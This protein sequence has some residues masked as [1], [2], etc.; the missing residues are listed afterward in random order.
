MVRVAIIGAGLMGGV[1]ARGYAT[2]SERV[3]L[4]LIHDVNPDRAAVLADT[5]GTE[6]ALTLDDVLDDPEVEAVTICVPPHLN[7]EIAVRALRAGKHVFLEKPIAL[8][9]E[10]ADAILAAA[11]QSRTVLMVGLVLRFWPGYAELRALACGGELG[12]P[13]TVTTSRLQPPAEWGGWISDVHLTGGIA[14]LVLVHD[15][16]QMNWLLGEPLHVAA[17]PL[18]GAGRAATHVGVWVD[19]G[20]ASGLA[21]ATMDMPS[22]YP[23]TSELRVV[24]ERGAVVYSFEAGGAEA[25]DSS[26]PGSG[27]QRLGASN[28]HH[29]SIYRDK[30]KSHEIVELGDGDLW[31]PELVHFLDAIEGR[32]PLGLGTGHQARQTLAVA[33]AANRSLESGAVERV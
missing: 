9:L 16:D 21:E 2:L 26:G 5:I 8:K 18:R 30:P 6:I 33:L 28:A 31:T 32:A 22:S 14:P 20:D 4:R 3:S 13:L 25:A 29:L 19:Y 10:D 27:E 7:R 17:R 24:C 23:L 11:E 15:F 1:H 12:R